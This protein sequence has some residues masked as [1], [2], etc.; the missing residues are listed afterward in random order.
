MIY[1]VYCIR[2]DAAQV[3]LTPVLEKND[4]LARRNFENACYSGYVNNQL[5][6]THP[7]DFALYKVATF[8]DE[9]AIF[10][11]LVPAELI[12]RGSMALY[13]KLRGGDKDE[14]S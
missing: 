6:G 9:K 1:G 8:D 7:Q 14:V 4:L 2:D 13:R 5:L 11:Q 12:C 10:D 3:F